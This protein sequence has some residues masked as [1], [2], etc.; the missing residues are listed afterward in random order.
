MNTLIE[1]YEKFIA[2]NIPQQLIIEKPG[3]TIVSNL[4]WNDIF[5]YI[6]SEH[7][8]RSGKHTCPHLESLYDHLIKCAS[9]CYEKAYT[10]GYTK[11]ECIKA[12]FTGLLHDIGK[13]GSRKI[14]GD[15]HIAFKGHGLIG[16]AM[17]EDFYSDVLF[18]LFGLTR[19]DWA[20]IST[21]A[22]VH[23]CSYSNTDQ[24]TALHQYSVN[25]LPDSVKKMLFV[26]RTG[27]KLGRTLENTTFE[28]EKVVVDSGD[29]DYYNTLFSSIPFN[30]VNKKK[31]ILIMLQGGSSNGK[32]TFAN[33]LISML[34]SDKTVHINR[35]WY[36]VH[37][38]LKNSGMNPNITMSDISPSLYQLCYTKYIAS[39]KKWAIAM[40]NHM[41]KDIY[42]GLQ[43]GLIVIVDTLA[44]MFDS[45][46]A[47]IPEIASNAYRI[48]FWLHRNT[49]ITESETSG[50]LG[51]TMKDQLAAHGETNLYNRFNTSIGW[52]HMVSTTESSEDNYTQPHLSISV[53]WTGMK[54]NIINHIC[55]KILTMYQY[56]MSIPRVPVMEQTMDMTLIELVQT[57]MD[58]DGMDCLLEFFK[59]Y[60]YTVS[61]Y[62]PGVVGIKYIDG[63]NQ[64]WRPKWARE[65][66]GRFYYVGGSKVIGL[67]DSLQRGIEV[68]TKAHNDSGINETQ[69]IDLKTLEKL[70]PIQQQ[71]MKTFSGENPIETF[72]TGKV[73]GSLIIVNIY[74]MGCE[75][76]DI[77][78]M[79]AMT[80]GD[81]FTKD[82]VSYCIKMGLPTITVATQGT[83]FIGE[84]M[85]DYFLTAIQSLGLVGKWDEIIPQFVDMFVDYT[86]GMDQM[87][88]M[89]FEAY[90][91]NRLTINGRLHTELAV[92]YDHN[93]FNLLGMMS[94]N[95][96]VPHFDMPRKTFKQPF[97]YKVTNTSDVF[98]LMQ[99]MDKVVLGSMTESEF[100]AHFNIDMLTSTVVHPEG[101]V[102]LTP[103]INGYD[104]AKIKTTMYYNCHKVRQTKVKEMLSYPMSCATYYPILVSLHTFFDNTVASINNLVT[105]TM[106]A[107][108]SNITK[109]SPF[110]TSQNQ[111][112]Q[113]RFNEVLD[114]EM[115]NIG[116][117]YKMMLNSRVN[118]DDLTKLISPITMKLYN[119]E[120]EGIISFTK[121]LLMKIEPWRSLW[122]TRLNTLFGSF[123][124]AVNE[125]YSIVIGF[126]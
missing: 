17:L 119:T 88:N 48:S 2:V 93:G 57:L 100:L 73:D 44:T 28:E 95:K 15:K 115:K 39:N 49:M 29:N 94:C 1:L 103:T 77:I 5:D 64:I 38:T 27:D 56:N 8:H 82:I 112:A 83:L 66:R 35:D 47:I 121:N 126:N 72:V 69:D 122:E 89:C 59:Q 105:D 80:Y 63:I 74:P 111:G 124:D 102:M 67:K 91:K 117:V 10:I 16:G 36:M 65:A 98:H 92:G 107:L 33:Y 24:S 45:I 62:I 87:S 11:H 75:Q 70:D 55:D 120:S 123:D 31:G 52:R 68:L 108:T 118:M 3:Q 106:D 90:C 9:V 50:R 109:S 125:L 22:D 116:V 110:Y 13:P 51:M 86:Q 14:V 6:K 96:Y 81:Q 61:K 76:Y 104:Y 23:M 60:H 46:N 21:C 114:G 78:N 19:D 20:D 12:Y 4:T 79:L 34:G 99:C 25:I 85:Q 26:L 58:T 84:D 30:L 71:I 53:G 40:N 101:F 18:T 42:E 97:Y 41:M 37:H 32:T 54:N 113:K 43:M 7:W